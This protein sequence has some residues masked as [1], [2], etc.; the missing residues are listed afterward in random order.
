MKLVTA[1]QMR[2]LDSLAIKRHHIPSLELM[3]KAG[4]GV[5]DAAEH[6]ANKEKGDVLII[7]GKGNN[8]GDG[9]V[10]ARHLVKRG[11]P[12]SVVILSQQSSLSPDAK[13]N[14]ELLAPITTHIFTAV[15]WLEMNS[16]LHLFSKASLIIDAV[17][18][19][20]LKND[21]T[22]FAA[23]IIELI[24]SCGKRVLSVDIPSGLSADTGHPLGVAVKANNTV[25][26]GLPKIGHVVGRGTEYSGVIK[27]VD[28]GIP[29]SEVDLL[30]SKLNLIEPLSFREYFRKREPDSHKGTYGHIAVFAG[31][32]GHLG[33]GYLSC[34]SAL[35]CGCGLTTY[36]IPEKA[37]AY[38]DT[39]YSEVMCDMIPDHGSSHFHTDGLEAALNVLKAM[40]AA[41]IGPAIGTQ[42]ET[43]A[44]VNAFVMKCE[45]PLVI[46]ADALNLLE[47]A[48]LRRRSVD[49]V[50]TPHPGEMSRLLGITIEEVQGNRIDLSSKLAKDYGCYVIL[51]G[52]NTVV[53]SPEGSIGI[54][55]TGN[56]GMASAG[57]GDALTGMITSFI[58]QGIPVWESSLAAVYIH[59]LAG[60]LAAKKHGE[61]A[62]IT[63]DLIKE[64]S[65]V[66]KELEG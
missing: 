54:N 44:F 17:L 5:A 48:S 32:K 19:T 9:L 24:N 21:V 4:S 7:C 47:L 28:I 42:E 58:S 40:K 6:L 33:A 29:Q 63:S 3:E 59:G 14:W 62:L 65:K 49:T 12:V 13:A 26:F 10:A 43:K 60:D 2:D 16:H 34:K 39:R 66:I 8:G 25:T 38:F 52:M 56:P 1:Q 46:D 22:G 27:I 31:S 53:A 18:G 41:C 55:I 20:G 23:Q 61:R 11:Y 50:L 64:I 15:D 57:M 36:C 37:F 51:K 30:E 35:R 45:I